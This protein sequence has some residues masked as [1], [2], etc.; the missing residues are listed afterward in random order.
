MI[1][2]LN[3]GITCVCN[4]TNVHQ[5][6]PVYV[7]D[8]DTLWKL[9]R[10]LLQRNAGS[11]VFIDNLTGRAVTAR[12]TYLNTCWEGVDTRGQTFRTTIIIKLAVKRTWRAWETQ[13]QYQGECKNDL[14]LPDTYYDRISYLHTK[15]IFSKNYALCTMVIYKT[16]CII[17]WLLYKLNVLKP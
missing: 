6:E 8:T 2:I 13:Q 5:M 9:T 16:V 15:K 17:T 10:T 12:W 1:V 3:C 11:S 14:R 4:I 7:I